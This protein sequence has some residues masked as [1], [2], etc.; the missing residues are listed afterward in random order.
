MQELKNAFLKR[1]KEKLLDAWNGVYQ[2]NGPR[3]RTTPKQRAKYYGWYLILEANLKH[4]N[5]PRGTIKVLKKLF[6]GKVKPTK[7]QYEELVRSFSNQTKRPT[8]LV[9]TLLSQI[10]K[11]IAT[12]KEYS[13]T[14]GF[15]PR[16]QNLFKMHCDEFTKTLKTIQGFQ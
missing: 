2:K 4:N 3:G 10:I 5:V 7:K 11:D 12:V 14:A 13:Q 8:L 6:D 1:E 15:S 16:A 9:R